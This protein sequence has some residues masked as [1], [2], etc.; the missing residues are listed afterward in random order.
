MRHSIVVL[1]FA[2]ALALAA[3]GTT[4]PA[5]GGA[6]ANG[7]TISGA[8]ARPSTAAMAEGGMGEGGMGNGAAYMVIGNSAAQPDRLLAATG[9]IAGTIELHTVEDK[10]GVMAMRPVDGVDVPAGGQVELKPGSFHVMMIGLKQELKPG[11]R[12]SLTLR[13]QNAGEV[14]VEAEVRSE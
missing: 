5:G 9:D 3:C 14:R 4:A 13:F 2:A 11:D 12:I 6:S 8:W 7:I 10:D 1:L